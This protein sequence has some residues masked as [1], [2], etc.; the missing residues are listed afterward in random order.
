VIG[1]KESN[2]QLVDQD[3]PGPRRDLVGYGRR[4]PKVVWPDEAK[5][6]VNL[7]V[8]YEEGSEYSIPAGD[9]RN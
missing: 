2:L 3:V 4:P 1:A 6:A 9:V 5:V 7:V 8:N